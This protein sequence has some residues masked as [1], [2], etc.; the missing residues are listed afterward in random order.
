MN[1]V[2]IKLIRGV[3]AAAAQL[4]LDADAILSATGLE[5]SILSDID[6]YV[7]YAQYRNIWQEI[8]Q[9]SGQPEVGL[10]LADFAHAG[11]FDFL[12]YIMQS[13]LNL[14]ESLTRMIRYARL[15]HE[16][17]EFKLKSQGQVAQITHNVPT[18]TL[19][20]CASS[21][22]AI[23]N[24]LQRSRDMTGLN[25]QPISVGFRCPLPKNLTV[26][27][28][29][30]RCPLEFNQP[31]DSIQMDLEL[32]QRPMLKAEPGLCAVLER[33]GEDLLKRFPSVSTFLNNVRGV[34]IEELRKGNV[35]SEKISTRLGIVPR[36]LQRQ[37]REAGTSYR[38]VL[39]EIRRELSVY[40][41]RNSD[42]AICEVA[43]LLGFS[44]TSS[45]NRAFK[46]WYD[47]SPGEFRRLRSN[48]GV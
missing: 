2:S 12:G 5:P 15:L 37:L 11:T 47:L 21:Q 35:G 48:T 23:A 40:Y 17:V 39:D 6:A 7:T 44:E 25:L 32:L 14:G 13:S 1:R 20:V 43:F 36:T 8:T 26:Y 4:N 28:Q 27:Q 24:L 16:G 46:R 22:W 42:V 34:I 18:V 30:F 41:L 45:F 29:K 10:Q 3:L 38:E 19:P 9:R 33:Y 31:V